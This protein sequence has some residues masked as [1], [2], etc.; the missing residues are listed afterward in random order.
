MVL[1]E[2]DAREFGT[3]CSRTLS[4]QSQLFEHDIPLLPIIAIEISS[5]WNL[6]KNDVMAVRS[7]NL[8]RRPFLALEIMLIL[9]DTVAQQQFS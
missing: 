3:I 2:T 4:A 1:R 6:G 5:Q 7:D 9:D 8:L